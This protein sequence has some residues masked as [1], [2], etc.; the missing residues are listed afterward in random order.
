MKLE[1]MEFMRELQT[2]PL[3]LVV[4]GSAPVACVKMLRAVDFIKAVVI[5]KDPAKAEARVE[6]ITWLGRRALEKKR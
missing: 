3:P 4:K 5:S 6:Q 1:P 2:Q